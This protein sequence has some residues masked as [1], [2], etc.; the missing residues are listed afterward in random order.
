MQVAKL[1]ATTRGEAR[2]FAIRTDEAVTMGRSSGCD[3]PLRDGKVSRRHCQLSFAQGHV[4]VVDL[5]SSH[6]IQHR[7]MSKPLV[8]L[9]VGDGFH[10][11]DTFVRFADAVDA[12]DATLAAWFGPGG[13]HERRAAIDADDDVAGAGDFD[14]APAAGAPVAADAR[15][16]PV[17]ADEAAVSPPATP[18]RTGWDVFVPEPARAPMMLGAPVRRAA[19]SPPRE[20]AVSAGTTLSARLA[21]EAVVFSIHMALCVALLVG[22]KLAVG[23]DLYALF[24][25]TQ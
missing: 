11:G 24:G 10:L 2:A 6:G 22:L 19:G 5:G 3:V 23:F 21:A 25:L 14:E 15:P 9:A 13:P 4:V 17:F 16:A 7:G 8:A 18:A 20:G 1:T 12:D